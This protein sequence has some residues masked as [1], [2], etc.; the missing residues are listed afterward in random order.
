MKR[1]LAI[2]A[3]LGLFLVIGCA[4]DYDS[5]LKNTIDNRIYQRRLDNNLEAAPKKTNLETSKI[6]VRPPKGL[7]GPTQTFGLAVVEPGKFDIEDTF[8]DQQRQASL[9]VLARLNLPKAPTKKAGNPVES[10]PRGEFTAD[11]LDLLKNVY[12]TD[13]DPAKLKSESKSH[14]RRT[15]TFRTM[16]L[17]LTAKEVKVYLLDDKSS[18]EKVALIFDYPK[19]QRENLSSKINLCLESFAV[20]E[21]A[22]RAYSGLVDEELGEEGGGAQPPGGVF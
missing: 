21:E 9:H 20:G 12:G 7:Q 13:F 14:G 11:V 5:R 16:T 18:P 8:F 4:Q 3:S 10:A 19:E 22:R 1:V 6:H 15:N 17:D 2:Q